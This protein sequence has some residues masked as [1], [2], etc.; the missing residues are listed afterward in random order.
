MGKKK[1][2]WLTI[3]VNNILNL[4]LPNEW[5]NREFNACIRTEL[6]KTAQ[7]MVKSSL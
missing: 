3:L 7:I 1:I 4:R 5:E 6:F 2:V